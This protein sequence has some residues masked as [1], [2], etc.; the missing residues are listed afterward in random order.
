MRPMLSE[1]IL[2]PSQWDDLTISPQDCAPKRLMYA[3][4]HD[5]L[6]LIPSQHWPQ[7]RRAS[8]LAREALEWV[9]KDETQW[10]FSFVNICVVLGLDV[11]AT[12]AA[13]HQARPPQLPVSPHRSRYDILIHAL[14]ADREQVQTILCDS[15]ESANRRRSALITTFAAKSPFPDGY[16]VRTKVV[17]SLP[18]ISLLVWLEPMRQQCKE[19]PQLPRKGYERC[20]YH[21]TKVRDRAVERKQKKQSQT[22]TQSTAT[23]AGASR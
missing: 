17:S 13:I 21:L 18:P 5:A 8:R 14:C 22:V 11:E 1:N 6:H 23:A 9:E 12:R 10:P 20:Q 7:G 3:V 19:C 2:L 16:C 4:L 15:K